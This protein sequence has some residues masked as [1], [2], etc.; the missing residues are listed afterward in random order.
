M[1][2]G[3]LFC[4]LFACLIFTARVVAQAPKSDDLIKA[5]AALE[6]ASAAYRAA[7]S[8]EDTFTYTVKAPNAD[9]AP[10]AMVIR[11]GQGTDVSVSDPLLEAVAQGDTLYLTK[12]D[13]LGLYVTRPYA[14][15][16]GKTLDSLVGTEGSLFEP[17]QVALRLGKG[18]DGCIESLRF[19]MLGPLRV[20]GFQS[21]AG[22]TGK[23]EEIIRFAA[24]NG[25]VEARIDATTHFFMSLLLNTHPSRAPEGVSV[26]I[27]GAFSPRVVAKLANLL[28]FDPGG[29]RS[30]PGLGDLVSK[31]LPVGN[32]APLLELKTADGSLVSLQSFKGR[33]V[34]ID[35]WATWCAPCWKTLRETQKLFDWATSSGLPVTILALNTMEQFAT[36]EIRQARVLAF[37]KS[38]KFTMPTLL[39]RG[40][41]AFK[42]F[43]SPGLPSMV[44]IAPDGTLFKY[45]QGLFPNVVETV[46]NDV[47]RALAG[48]RG[49]S[50]TA[51]VR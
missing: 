32:L 9:L 10:K 36:E 24:D 34:V 29:R 12:S 16:F 50:N 4:P 44:I 39:D 18:A 15:D 13:A 49:P 33:V 25:R 3:R 43:K 17:P 51:L 46:R 28:S 35:F 22:E 26:E 2:A 45:Y 31:S 5:R 20:V 47:N 7:P 14:G 21:A 30:V 37:F 6:A 1:R 42:A 40:D 23:N 19:K 41:E 8:L 27:K 11:L 38:Q 48:T